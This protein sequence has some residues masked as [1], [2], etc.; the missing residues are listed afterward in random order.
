[1]AKGI[2]SKL[3]QALKTIPAMVVEFVVSCQR[4]IKFDDF[5]PVCIRRL[6]KFFSNVGEGKKVAPCMVPNSIDNDANAARFGFF[7][8]F[9]KELVRSRPLPVARIARLFCYQLEVSLG[10]RSEVGIN[11]VKA[12]SIVFM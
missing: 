4:I 9:K 12:V 6:L 5:I 2:I 8:K 10:V 7:Q 1:M 3:R 11:M